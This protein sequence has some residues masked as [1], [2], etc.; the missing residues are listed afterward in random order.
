MDGLIL[1]RS[2]IAEKPYYV[3]TGDIYLYSVEELCYYIYNNIYLLPADFFNERLVCFID[4]QLKE[5]QLAKELSS[6]IA[7]KAGIGDAVLTILMYVDYYTQEEIRAL[8]EVIGM[9]DSM[10]PCERLKAGGDSFLAAGRYF[11][12]LEKYSGSLVAADKEH[13]GDDF[14]AKIY[15]N[16]GVVY[17][18]LLLYHQAAECFEK[19]Y[20]LGGYEESKKQYYIALR[21]AGEECAEVLEEDEEMLCEAVHE[22]ES[23][24]DHASVS[25]SCQEVLH[26]L[27]WNNDQCNALI[28]KFKEE[29]LTCMG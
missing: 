20:K 29:C 2:E 4:E 8:R 3:G 15:H 25:T 12:A 5:K 16:E 6:L 24:M 19:A 22:I 14:V 10:P 1:C 23:A 11:S 7:A 26:T 13:A 17:G 18:R 21:L 27:A 9:L 28:E